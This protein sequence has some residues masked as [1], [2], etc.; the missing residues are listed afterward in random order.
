MFNG[1]CRAVEWW[2]QE[3]DKENLLPIRFSITLQPIDNLN[4]PYF[5]SFD[6]FIMQNAQIAYGAIAKAIAKEW[7]TPLNHWQQVSQK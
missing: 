4:I 2:T 3:V 5:L 6:P 1:W 7:E